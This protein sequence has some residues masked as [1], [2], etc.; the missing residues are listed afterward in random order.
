[1]D[2]ILK[3]SNRE[4]DEKKRKYKIKSKIFREDKSVK[5]EINV[6]QPGSLYRKIK[7]EH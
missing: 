5:K 1:M 7:I 3:D 4:G 6:K 2:E